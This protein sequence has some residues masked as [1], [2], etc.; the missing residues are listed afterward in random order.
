M[1]LNSLP[2]SKMRWFVEYKKGDMLLVVPK[3][4]HTT[5]M[6]SEEKLILGSQSEGEISLFTHT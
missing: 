1:G 5:W 4:A 2:F 6:G 3:Q